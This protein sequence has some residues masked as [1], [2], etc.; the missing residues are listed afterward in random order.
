[1]EVS[2]KKWLEFQTL[3]GGLEPPKQNPIDRLPGKGQSIGA[4]AD[5]HSK[6]SE[7]LPPIKRK[8]KKK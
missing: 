2:F 4:V 1:M 6:G 7:E 8:M 3:G 5:Y